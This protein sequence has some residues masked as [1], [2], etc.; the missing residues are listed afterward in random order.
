MLGTP[1]ISSDYVL[2]VCHVVQ[3]HPPEGTQPDYGKHIFIA[4]ILA[5]KELHFK[6]TT[7]EK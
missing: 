2:P 7:H 6:S 4:A 1:P 5:T 3:G